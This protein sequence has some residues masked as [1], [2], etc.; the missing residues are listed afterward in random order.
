M[1]NNK[2]MRITV[3]RD[4]FKIISFG[5]VKERNLHKYTAP[6]GRYIN[7]NPRY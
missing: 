7:L 3:L 1:V 6:G 2:S 4:E 5:I